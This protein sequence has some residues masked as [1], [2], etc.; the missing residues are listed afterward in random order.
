MR[1]PR[2]NSSSRECRRLHR[3]NEVGLHT[4][5]PSRESQDALRAAAG[6]NSDRTASCARSAQRAKGSMPPF[7]IKT[8]GSKSMVTGSGLHAAGCSR[9]HLSAG[10]VLLKSTRSRPIPFQGPAFNAHARI[11]ADRGLRT[12]SYR[13]LLSQRS[14]RARAPARFPKMNSRSAPSQAEL[15]NENLI[16]FTGEARIPGL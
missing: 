10:L 7:R 14:V 6:G 2:G 12:P 13:C 3:E 15:K 4:G 9:S 8:I 11:A 5:S 1:A 16:F